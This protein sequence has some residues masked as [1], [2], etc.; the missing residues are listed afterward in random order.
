[1]VAACATALAVCPT[2]WGSHN[3]TT[4]VSTGPA[5]GNGAV[6]SQFRGASAD[7]TRVF[8]Q[9]NEALVTADTDTRM[10]IYERLGATT[11]L[12][13][14]GP[15]GGN[16][17]FGASFAANSAAGTRVFFRTSEQLV[18]G[19]TDTTQDLYERFNGTTT[20]M[21][22]GPTGGNGAF[23][24]I[25]SGISQDGSRVLFSTA[26]SLVSTDADGGWTDVYQRSNGTTTLISTG[27]LGGNAPFEATYAGKSQDGARVFFHTDE[28]LEGSDVDTSQDVYARS[29]GATSHLSIGPAG[30]NG[31]DDFDYD[32]FFDGASVDGSIAWLHTDEV[33]VGGDTDTANDVYERAG[34]A[35][36]LVSGGNAD[37]GAYW[38]GSSENGSRVFFDTQEALVGQDSDPSTDIYERAAGVTTLIS[39]GPDGGNGAVFSAFQG[40]TADGSRVFFHTADSLLT[41][42]TDGMQDVYERAAGVTTLVS[43]G[44]G[45]ANGLYPAAFK[46]AS[47]DGTRV[48]FDT[49]EHLD[50]VASG[51][52][53]D[54][55]ERHAGTTTFISV[56][57]T[58]GNG[59]FFAFVGGVSDDGTRLFFETDEALVSSDTDISQDVYSSSITTGAYAR[60]KGAG[61]L[62]VSLVPAYDQCTAPNRV[63][64]SPLSHPSCNPPVQSS[65]Q[66]T[67][68]SPDANQRTANSIGSAKLRV[69]PGNAGAPDEA[70]VVFTASITDVRLKS[71]LSD[72]TGELEL[73]AVLRITDKLNGTAPVD[74]GTTADLPFPVTVPCAATVNTGIGSTCS[75]NTT[76]DA[77][78]PGAVQELKRTIW[79]LAAV[80]VNDGGP[81]GLAATPDN[82]L[83]AT[84][85]IFVP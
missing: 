3:V 31:N 83:F 37:T 66:L 69:V 32:A 84:Q 6:S 4:V 18:S 33:L 44:P 9:S 65:G 10:D 52:Y 74:S 77:V 62:R 34:A 5:G 7:G 8:F 80:R 21:S 47:R 60:P 41:Q 25:F 61:P 12:L 71:D 2:A 75:V 59:D 13:S 19:D 24:V 43:Q 38:A 15:T 20:L 63:H 76:A 49:S 48:F 57:P 46:G 68:G 35:I 45:S 28:P 16:G 55:Y 51:I 58:G 56:G 73:A 42:D 36:T 17:A 64:G 72:Y 27:A 54:I 26:E 81:D 30:G 85:G 22:T 11:T 78:L 29:G 79:Q 70:D 53:P 82:T 50:A 1:M 14:T 40:A 23:Q 39:T 67:I